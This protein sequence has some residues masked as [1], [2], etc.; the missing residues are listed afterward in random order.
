M[1]KRI[2]KKMKAKDKLKNISHH[3]WYEF[4]MFS[5]LTQ[6][7]GKGYLPSIINNALLESFALHARNL[8]DFLYAEDPS[9]DDVYAGDFF[10]CKEDWVKIRPQITPLLEKV[11]KRAN[12]EVSH[13]TYLRIKVTQEEKKWHFVKIFQEMGCAFDVFVGKVD[14]ELLSHEWTD[15]LQTRENCKKHLTTHF[16]GP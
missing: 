13:L 2:N 14:E 16:S 8:I 4:T 12:K 11:K 7:L 3:L 9:S 15:F 10:P 6:E 1:E 5:E